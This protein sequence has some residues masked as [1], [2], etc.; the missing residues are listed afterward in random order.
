MFQLLLEAFVCVND[1]VDVVALVVFAV[2][3]VDVAMLSVL[4]M[5]LMLLLVNSDVVD[6]VAAVDVLN[7]V[8]LRYI[9]II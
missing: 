6:F 4:L 3:V 2:D 9:Y 7:F 8:S 5:F 1:V